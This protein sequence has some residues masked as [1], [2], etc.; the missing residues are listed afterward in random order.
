MADDPI[1][2]QLCPYQVTLEGGRTYSWC[3]CG[4]SKKQP[5]CDGSHRGT[6]LEPVRFVASATGTVN[7][8]GCKSTDDQPF[9]DGSHN[10]L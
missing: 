2:A 6:G 7:L 9:C 3:S 5:F 1:P 4:R 10:V 8:C